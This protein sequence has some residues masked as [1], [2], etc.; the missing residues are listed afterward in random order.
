[1]KLEEVLAAY[2]AGKAIKSDSRG[3]S[4]RQ[5]EAGFAGAVFN[6]ADFDADDWE[7]VPTIRTGTFTEAMEAAARGA[8]VKPKDDGIWMKFAYKFILG[9][10]LIFDDTDLLTPPVFGD[11]LTATWEIKE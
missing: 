9:I 2:R 7:I 1:M 5:R 3:Q 10:V 11:W 4:Y 6:L 8:R